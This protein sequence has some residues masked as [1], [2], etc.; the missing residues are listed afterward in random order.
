M[1]LS[2]TC[3]CNWDYSKKISVFISV[4]KLYILYSL[5]FNFF[6]L[7]IHFLNKCTNYCI[8]LYSTIEKLEVSKIFLKKCILLF[9]KDALNW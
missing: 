5:L 3:I 2:V 9:S 8:Y 7:Y 4:I 6:L 1:Y